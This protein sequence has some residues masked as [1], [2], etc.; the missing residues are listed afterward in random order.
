MKRIAVGAA[1]AALLAAGGCSQKSGE[2]AAAPKGGPGGGRQR[3]YSVRTE[4]VSVRPVQYEIETHGAVEAQDVYRIDARVAGTVEDVAFNEGDE[5]TPAKVLCRISPLAYELAA[6][7]AEAAYRKSV[8]DL[9]DMQR[10]TR[11]EVELARVRL[12]QADIELERRRVVREAGAIAEEEVQLYAA[13]RDLNAIELKSME[14]AAITQLEVMQATIR[15]KEADWKIAE[16]SVRKSAVLPPIEGV[17][18][19]RLVT[20]GMQVPQGTAI[21]RLVDKRVMRLKFTLAESKAPHVQI[22][23]DLTFRVEAYPAR[24]FKA[25]VYRIG[26]LTDTQTRLVTCWA[27]VE[28]SDA[29]L[30]AGFFATIALVS[31]AKKQAV[32]VPVNATLPTEK[33]FV[34]YVVENGKAVQRSL[35]LGLHVTGDAVEVL[36]GLKEGETVV[37]EGANALQPNVEVT[38][39]GKKGATALKTTA[40][41]KAG[42]VKKETR[43]DKS[44]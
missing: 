3:A 4:Q 25:K 7:K 11:I 18:E 6:K 14:G 19:E 22:G 39:I 5:V 20:N 30:K 38:D 28:P 44:P 27:R 1:F 33:G 32:V 35:K 41:E 9:T 31:E 16:E 42:E 12:K 15:E 24:A 2:P 40:E 29:N 21:A 36:S 13:R 37:V 43:N 17:I 34:A 26:D 23:T 10:R 8:A